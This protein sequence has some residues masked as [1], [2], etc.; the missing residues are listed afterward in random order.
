MKSAKVENDKTGG[1]YIQ[2]VQYM[3]S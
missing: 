2:E 1:E 3:I